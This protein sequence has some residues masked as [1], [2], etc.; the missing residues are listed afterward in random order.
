MLVQVHSLHPSDEN[1]GCKSRSGQ[2]MG[3]ARKVLDCQ[4]TK[5]KSKKKVI[6]E[7]QKGKEQSILLRRWTSVSSKM[8]SW[9]RSVK[10]TR[11]GLCSEVT[12]Q[13][14]M[15]YSQSKVRLRHK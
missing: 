2:R 5:V 12:L 6:L 11:A 8:R 4:M 7:A 14:R 13:A 3:E 1:S 15:Q 9:N 10:S